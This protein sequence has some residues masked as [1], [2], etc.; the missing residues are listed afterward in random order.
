MKELVS[1]IFFILLPAVFVIVA[2][3][4][5]VRLFQRETVDTGRKIP[6][7]T[8]RAK[9]V[10]KRKQYISYANRGSLTFYYVSFDLGNSEI[11][12]FKVS[13]GEFKRLNFNDEVTLTHQ[14]EKFISVKIIQKSGITTEPT[15]SYGA[16]FTDII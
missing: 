3:V 8:V 5:L 14:G 15:E 7:T 1:L 11:M 4:I 6:K 13:K 10:D 12:E 2:I 9:V 16:N